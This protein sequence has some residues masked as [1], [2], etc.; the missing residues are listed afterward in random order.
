M[1]E[2]NPD[3]EQPAHPGMLTDLPYDEQLLLPGSALE[4]E[5]YAA[6]ENEQFELHLQ[7]QINLQH[8]SLSGAEVLLR[9]QHPAYGLIPPAYFIPVL[10]DSGMLD[11][12]GQWVLQQTCKLNRR[13]QDSG[14]A[15]LRFAINVW[16]SQLEQDN[17]LAMLTETLD[18]SGLPPECLELELTENG[19]LEGLDEN[20]ALFDELRQAG[21]RLALNYSGEGSSS[22][23]NF[24]ELPIDVIKIDKR[25]IQ[26]IANNRDRRELL[27]TILSFAHEQGLQ[28]VA[29]GVETAAQLLF[30]KAMHCQTAQGFLLSHP[31]SVESFTQ[32]YQAGTGFEHLVEKVGRQW[33]T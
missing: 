9:W 13:W 29:E 8:W 32:L 27:A 33:Q 24:H 6:L 1:T 21:I 16:N 11:E 2:H 30:L 20:S 17:F 28:V 26:R 18:S 3:F 19:L 31:L 22:D 14:L 10:E 12:V 4:K 15:P 7:P 5:L 23:G 25:L